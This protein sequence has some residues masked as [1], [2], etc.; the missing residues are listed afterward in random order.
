M[1]AHA[2]L[3]ASKASI[4]INCPPSAR[5]TE[6]IPDKGGIYA[7]EGTVAHK[8][9][10]IKLRRNL[11]ICNSSQRAALDKELGRLKQNQYYNTEMENIIQEYA[12]LVAERFMEA[13]ARSSDAQILLEKQINLSEWAPESF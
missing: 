3:S 2:L 10:E 6:K 8:L 13:K 9:A 5:L 12:E 7:D 11:T 4:W 1:P